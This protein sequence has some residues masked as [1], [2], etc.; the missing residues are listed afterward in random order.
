MQ[1][2]I[3]TLLNYINCCIDQDTN[4]DIAKCLLLNIRILSKLSLEDTAELCNVSSSTLKRFCKVIGFDN[5]STIKKLL[6]NHDLPFNYDGLIENHDNGKYLET[7][8]NG[9]QAIDG[10]SKEVFE[11]LAKMIERADHIYLL[12]YGDFHYQALYLQN[13]MLYHGKL[14]EIINQ[15]ERLNSPIKVNKEDLIIVTSLS[16]GYALNMASKLS[17]MDCKKVLITKEYKDMPVEF[18]LLLELGMSQDENVNKYLIMRIFEKIISG[19]YY[20]KTGQKV[21]CT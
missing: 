17:K 5:Y 12:G 16:G 15:N 8:Y 13:V 3:Y 6:R 20:Y 11:D 7:L 18:D 14:F 1:I 10:I 2:V 9:L 21:N 19:Y 4:Y